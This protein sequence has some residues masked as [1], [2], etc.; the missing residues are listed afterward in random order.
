MAAPYVPVAGTAIA[1]AAL[2]EN[3]TIQQCLYWIGFRTVAQRT[4]LVDNAYGSYDDIK[5]LSDKDISSMSSDWARRTVAGGR[6]HFGTTQTKYLKAFTH[7]VTDFYRI[8]NV[9]H[10]GGLNEAQFWTALQRAI[11]RSEVRTNIKEH[12]STAADAASPGPLE[13]ERK[14]KNWEEKFINYLY[15]QIGA[16]GVPLSY[17]IRENDAPNVGEHSTTFY[18]KQSS[19][20]RCRA[21]STM[22]IQFNSVLHHRT[23]IG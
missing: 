16:F 13:S 12:S 19:V 22:P 4:S 9:P 17:V 15:T 23:A 3:K 7:W 11:A 21:S 20:C 2:S 5:M 8:S 1:P 18:H 10:V 14:W 6:I